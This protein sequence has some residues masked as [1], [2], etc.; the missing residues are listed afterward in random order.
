MNKTMFP[1]YDA[2]CQQTALEIQKELSKNPRLMLCIA[3]GNT[4]LGIFQALIEAYLNGSVSF[5]QASFVAMDEWLDMNEKTPDSCG[6]FLVEHFLKHVD[7]PSEHIRLWDGCSQDPQQECRDVEA[8]IRNN[9]AH[10][11]IDYLV[12]GMGMNG[13]LALNEPGCDFRGRAHVCDLD[14]VTQRVGQKYFREGAS[15]SGGITLGIGN[16]RDARR[17]VLLANGSHKAA[18]VKKLLEAPAATA[19]FPA[20]ALWEFDDASFYYDKEAAALL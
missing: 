13:H 11:V 19:G 1:S 2:M 18:V 5:R 10:G 9:S 3:A 7:F 6:N 20:T 12:L 4:S 14:P 17:T 8:F 15:L 16:F